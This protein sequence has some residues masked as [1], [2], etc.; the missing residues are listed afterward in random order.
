MTR[1]SQPYVL[2]TLI[3]LIALGCQPY[4]NIPKQTADTASHDP[5]GKTVRE[6]MVVAL[7]AAMDDGDIAGP[8][9]L[10]LPEHT[11]MLTYTY[12]ANALEGRAIVP[13][14]EAM[15]AVNGVIF[16]KGIRIRGNKGEVDII[17]PIGDGLDQLVT[18]RVTFSIPSGWRAKDVRVWRGVPI[19]D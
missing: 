4:V 14:D 18:V 6:V 12:I 19:E 1:K 7:R 2:L 11:N 3:S 16:V 15:A 10:M 17:R 5:N 9:Q 13:D 8:V